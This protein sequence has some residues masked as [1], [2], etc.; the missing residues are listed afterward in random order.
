[1]NV[2]ILTVANMNKHSVKCLQGINFS[3]LTLAEKTE[4]KNVGHAT[5]DVVI[6]Q[7]LSRRK[8]TCE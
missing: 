4:T 8:E 1:V 7:P 2:L 6:S 3:Q 5:S